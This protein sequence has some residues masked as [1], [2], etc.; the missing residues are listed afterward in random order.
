MKCPKCEHNQKYSDGMC[1]SECYYQFILDPKADKM[2]DYKM[3]KRVEQVGEQGTRHFTLHQLYALYRRKEKER[4]WQLKVVASVIIAL[5]VFSYGNVYFAILLSIVLFVIGLR[6]TYFRFRLPMEAFDKA[7]YKWYKQTKD[8]ELRKAVLKPNLK[9]K[10]KGNKE[11]DIYDYGVEA[12]I[13]T[14][15]DMYV[16]LFV[17]NNYHIQYKALIISENLY[18]YYLKPQLKQLLVDSPDLPVFFMHDA[19]K[20]GVGTMEY[21]RSLEELQIE[22]H[23]CIDLGLTPQHF[24]KLKPLKKLR[25]IVSED[26][27][28][29]DFLQHKH[30]VAIFN[31][32]IVERAEKMALT[33]EGELIE[34]GGLSD[35]IVLADLVADDFG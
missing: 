5:L 2:N 15:R 22:G 16:D 33:D 30:F 21:V 35:T 29:L 8:V 11:D 25:K 23:P 13:V 31:K 1:C 27:A 32:Y 28:P 12:I 10:P 18:P 20:E 19:T 14:D 34:T 6:K 4:Y 26:Y 9:K 17:K 24:R 3:Q 7:F